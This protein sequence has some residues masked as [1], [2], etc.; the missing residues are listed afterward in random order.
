[1]ADKF[2]DNFDKSFTDSRDPFEIIEFGRAFTTVP[3]KKISKIFKKY[4][5]L[6]KEDLVIFSL[7]KRQYLKRKL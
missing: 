1:M 2:D 4:L 5:T 3:D 7:Q 6:T